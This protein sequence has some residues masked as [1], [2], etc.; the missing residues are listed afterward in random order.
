MTGAYEGRLEIL[1]KAYLTNNRKE[2]SF[3]DLAL[4]LG[5]LSEKVVD[6]KVILVK[7]KQPSAEHETLVCK[8]MIAA[9]RRNIDL[10]NSY[11]KDGRCWTGY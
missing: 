7:P 4:A 5:C 11:M 3:A 1:L 8:T 10:D 2:A 9:L 6:R